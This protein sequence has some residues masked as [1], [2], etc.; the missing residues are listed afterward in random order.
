MEPIK[1][2][3]TDMENSKRRQW[4]SIFHTRNGR[5]PSARR[6]TLDVIRILKTKIIGIIDRLYSIGHQPVHHQSQDNSQHDVVFPVN[7]HDL[8]RKQIQSTRTRTPLE[9]A[10]ACGV[11]FSLLVCQNWSCFRSEDK[12]VKK[13]MRLCFRLYNL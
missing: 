11:A 3:R 12:T 9:S 13:Y 7:H 4:S 1:I 10:L 5:Q 6:I 8:S 2:E